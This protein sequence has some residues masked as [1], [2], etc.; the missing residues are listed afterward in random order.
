VAN[1]IHI[2]YRY[3]LRLVCL[4]VRFAQY[5]SDNPKCCF[6]FQYFCLFWLLR[7]RC[8]GMG[9][10]TFLCYYD[11]VDL[12]GEVLFLRKEGFFGVKKLIFFK[13]CL[14]VSSALLIIQNAVSEVTRLP[15]QK[16]EALR[17]ETEK[18]QRR[19]GSEELIAKV[20]SVFRMHCHA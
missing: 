17:Q 15:E 9:T 12:V 6:H 20:P 3:L 14:V 8:G 2:G 5:Y 19:Q 16:R 7:I 4:R 18:S 11:G 1:Q 13:L 10:S